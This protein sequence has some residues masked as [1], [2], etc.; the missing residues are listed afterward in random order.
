VLTPPG[1][2]DTN[3]AD[4][5]RADTAPFDPEEVPLLGE[6]LAVELA[7][8]LYVGDDEVV[9]FLADREW[10]AAWLC[11]LADLHDLTAPRLVA[12]EAAELRGLRDAVRDLLTA[13]M[14]RTA[15]PPVAV[16]VVNAHAAAGVPRAVLRWRAGQ[17]PSAAVE[18]DGD[19]G[20]ALRCRLAMAAVELL[21]ATD[22]DRFRR[23]EGPG[24]NLFFVQQHRRRRFCHESC[25][26]RARQQRYVQRHRRPR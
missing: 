21:A 2:A 17:T 25:G 4:T 19:P 24:C 14:D 22:A 3:P 10:A 11:Q 12:G 9:D 6:P 23:C 26:H 7:N 18:V 20:P 8:S 13:A 1:P 5:G 15:P 16:A